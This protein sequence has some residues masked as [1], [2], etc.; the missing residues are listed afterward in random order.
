MAVLTKIDSN[1][2]GLRYAEEDS[3]KT[4]SGDE[5]WYPLEPNSYSDFGGEITTVARNP[6]NPSRQRKKG[7]VTD[8]DASGGFE[9]DITQTNLQDLLQGFFFADVRDKNDVGAQ[10]QPM[11]F[12]TYG[13]WSDY[14]ITDLDTTA[15]EITVDSRVAVSAVVVAA[16][17][18]YADGDVVE[19]T[20]ANASVLARF[21]VT[22]ETAGAVDTVALTFS[23][24]TGGR[25]GRTHTDTGAGAV[26]T[27][28]TGSGDNA[29]TLTLTYGNGMVWQTGDVLLLAGNNDAANDGI[30][31][32]VSAA[33]NVITVSE[34][35]TTDAAPAATAIMTT[36]AFQGAAG[37]IDV[38]AVGD[39]PQLISTVLD[40]T[41]LGLIVGEWIYIG[42][43]LAIEAFSN[44]ENNGFARIRAIEA[45]ALTLDKT[46][47]DMVTE[48][49]TT[50]TIR[51]FFGRVLKN[52]TG[53]LI[54]RRTYQLERELG[55]PDDA[56]PAEVQA[57]YLTGCV[58][59]EF[60]FQVPTADKAV[61]SLSFVGADNETIDGPTSLKSGT[62]PDLVEAAAFN[63]SSDVPRIHM[64]IVDDTDSA[65]TALFA[66][67]EDISLTINNNLSPNKAIGV[68]GA[69]EVTAGTFE[70]GGTLT[71]YFAS[72]DAIDQ[73]RA[74][75]DITLDIH[76][77]KENSGMSIDLPL[78][79]L[80]DGRPDVTQD[81]AIKLPLSNEAATGAKIDSD[82]DHT[83]LMVFFDYLPDAAE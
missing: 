49:S 68:L 42:G 62:R 32:V 83:L 36:I 76:L 23:G 67:V 39:Q 61:A 25:E 2:T 10:R 72:V 65:P 33:D 26:T 24:F 69:F 53:S 41:T 4:V 20:D 29:L 80:G 81:Q 75:A 27:I 40:F 15:D 58:P 19:V 31:N 63:T 1:V 43:D 34:N 56:L 82:L 22:G 8:L 51:L 78:L 28:I 71:A 46:E 74:N 54:K 35:L 14:L 21:I 59:S 5:F 13:Q 12:G 52:E 57:E 60:E 79:S 70:V 64:A 47:A 38:N 45:T 66:F 17:T 55:A 18:G 48:A 77:V 11:G 16:G 37:D 7:V 6:I 73:V 50:E 3:Y 9:T 44:A 30:K